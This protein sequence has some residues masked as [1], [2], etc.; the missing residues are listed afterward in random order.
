M[1]E[2]VSIA[3]RPGLSAHLSAPL[4]DAFGKPAG[5]L[6]VRYAPADAAAPDGAVVA[7]AR[8]RRAPGRRLRAGGGRP[9]EGRRPR[10]AARGVA[11]PQPRAGDARHLPRAVAARVAAPVVAAPAHR[12]DGR[13]PDADRRGHRAAALADERGAAHAGRAAHRGRVAP[14]DGGFADGGPARARHRRHA[15]LRQ[16]RVLRPGGLRARGADR[17]RHADALLAARRDRRQHVAPPAQ[18]GRRR[19][20]RRLRGALGAQGR[21]AHRR[22]ALRGAAGRLERPPHRLDGLDPRHH[23]AQ[24]PRGTRAPP[25]R[26]DGAPGAAHDAGRGGL[27]ARAPAEPAADLDHRLRR[28]R[29]AP[30]GARGPARRAPRRRDDAPGRPGRRGRPHRQA[31]PRVPH[32]AQPAARDDGSRRGRAPRAGAAGARAAPA[33]AARGMG[34]RAGAAQ[35]RRRPGADRAGG[36]QPRAQRLRRDG[37]RAR[38]AAPAARQHLARGH[39]RDARRERRRRLPAAGRRRRRPRPARAQRRAAGD[40]VL[41][42]QARRHGHGPGDLPLHHRGAP[43]RLR[44]HR[45]RLR[46]RALLLHLARGR[47]LA[48]RRSCRTTTPSRPRTPRICHER[49][50]PR[51]PVRPNRWCTSSTTRRR[52]ATR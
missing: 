49:H 22:D 26:L 32:A 12:D 4:R 51:T 10:G 44:R 6:V 37:R 34:R 1:P 24:A 11:S 41:F 20:A 38:G 8:V 7:R 13:V 27:R 45:Q 18:H 35:G 23:R 25:D 5:H 31:H 29:Q 48:R 30:A 3:E 40:A 39:Q 46:R 14:G 36:A 28:G 21:P 17:P 42:D 16:P 15:G 19:A 2:G 33:A 9:A 50:C 47:H 43:R 52:C